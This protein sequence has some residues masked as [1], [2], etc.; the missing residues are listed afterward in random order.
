MS[1]TIDIQQLLDN[2]FKEAVD[3]IQL[4]EKLDNF[5]LLELYSYYKQ[6]IVGNNNTTEPSFLDFK[7]QAKWNVWNKLRGMPKQ[8]AQVKYIKLVAKFFILKQKKLIE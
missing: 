2:D 5:I 8:T 6:V 3:K 7:G 1:K 4:L